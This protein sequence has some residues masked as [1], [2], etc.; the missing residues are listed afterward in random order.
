MIYDPEDFYVTSSNVSPT[1]R[2]QDGLGRTLVCGLRISRTDQHS[3]S[4][5]RLWSL[6]FLGLNPTSAS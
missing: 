6:S 2:C 4:E 3:A 1:D 5:H